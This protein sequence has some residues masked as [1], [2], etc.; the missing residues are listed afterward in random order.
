MVGTRLEA[1][2]ELLQRLHPGE[3][4]LLQL[5]LHP[6]LMATAPFLLQHAAEE[7]AIVEFFCHRLPHT[8]YPRCSIFRR[9]RTYPV[10]AS[11][12]SEAGVLPYSPVATAVRSVPERATTA[13][14]QAV[15]DHKQLM[16]P[17][18]K[19]GIM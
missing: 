4:G 1:E 13:A 15:C 5:G 6:S 18:K 19:W 12:L 2:V 17:S 16:I 3:A 10:N 11:K 14:A 8:C 7:L 9:L